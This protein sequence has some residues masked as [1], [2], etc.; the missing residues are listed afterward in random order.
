MEKISLSVRQGKQAKFLVANCTC[1]YS[2]YDDMVGPY[3][4]TMVIW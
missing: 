2:L 3:D 1:P 4:R